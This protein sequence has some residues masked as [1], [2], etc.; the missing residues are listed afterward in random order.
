[1]DGGHPPG[2]CTVICCRDNCGARYVPRVR[3]IMRIW[4][5][6]NGIMHNCVDM[7]V[8]MGTGVNG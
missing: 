5:L 7:I 4:L 1:M 8:R 6:K 2:K 3:S